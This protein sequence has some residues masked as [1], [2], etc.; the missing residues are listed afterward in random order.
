MKQLEANSFKFE[1][2]SISDLSEKVYFGKLGIVQ[3][4]YNSL[5]KKSR[6]HNLVGKPN[7]VR[8]IAHVSCTKLFS[9][10]VFRKKK[11]ISTKF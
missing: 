10:I 7:I 1:K 3:I 4:M 6:F 11:T 9:Q 5:K 2:N 8:I